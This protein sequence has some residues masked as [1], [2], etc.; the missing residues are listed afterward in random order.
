MKPDNNH[1]DAIDQRLPQT[2]CTRCGYPRCYAYAQAIAAGEADIN[3]CPPGGDITI[4]ALANLTHTPIKALNPEF[5][6]T[7]P[8]H[9][10][11][12]REHDCIGCT[13]CIQACPV[14]A[15]LGSGKLMHT[16]V[17]DECTGCDLCVP[18]CPVDCI[19]MVP[20]LPN[21]TKFDSPWPEFSLEQV[22][23][24][25]RRTKNRIARLA[26]SQSRD[27]RKPSEEAKPSPQ[28]IRD[29][30][31]ASIARVRARRSGKSI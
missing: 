18:P 4:R 1:V 25:R 6:E 31:Q 17:R 22:A 16:V 10:A 14:D 7:G 24:A 8:R 23:R 9:V 28:I 2:Q 13:I 30:I 15:I 29:E 21:S 11:I 12:I 26:A 27:K 3:Q 20:L 19:D 5:G